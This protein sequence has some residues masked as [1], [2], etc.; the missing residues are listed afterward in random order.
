MKAYT[1]HIRN[2]AC[3]NQTWTLTNANGEKEEYYAIEGSPR[4][5]GTDELVEPEFATMLEQ[6]VQ[7]VDCDEDEV[8][9]FDVDLKTNSVS[10]VTR[11]AIG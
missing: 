10:N 6:F 1:L 3:I 8:V 9:E 7:M 4:I 2:E 11:T 5:T